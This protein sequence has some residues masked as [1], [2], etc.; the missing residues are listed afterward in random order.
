MLLL[1]TQGANVTMEQ[2][3]ARQ[4]RSKSVMAPVKGVGDAT[5]ATND[6]LHKPWVRAT[7]PFVNG[8]ISGMVATTVI[9]PV[10]M[11]KVRSKCF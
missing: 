1:E 11:V 3:S 2:Q 7:L 10:D 6:F 8:G 9:Q 4:I 5:A